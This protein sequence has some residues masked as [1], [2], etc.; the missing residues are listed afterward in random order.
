MREAEWERAGAAG[1]LK[2]TDQQFHWEN[3][4]YA[5]FDAFLEALSSRKRKTIRRE[6]RTRWRP[7]SP[8]STSPA[9]I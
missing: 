4:G 8:S 6:R 9:R 3:A 1:F 7:A 2:R 5:T